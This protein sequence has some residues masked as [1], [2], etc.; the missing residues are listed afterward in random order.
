[1]DKN[2]ISALNIQ[3]YFIIKVL[4][5]TRLSEVELIFDDICLEGMSRRKPSK[6]E[7][8]NLKYLSFYR[9]TLGF[10]LKKKDKRRKVIVVNAIAT[11][12]VF[13]VALSCMLIFSGKNKPS[14]A[15]NIEK[16]YS[17]RCERLGM[18]FIYATEG[19]DIKISVEQL[20]Y[21]KDHM[22]KD[23]SYKLD[24]E[25]AKR[26]ERHNLYAD[27]INDEQT[28]CEAATFNY[29]G[30]ENEEKLEYVQGDRKYVFNEVYNI[31]FVI[32]KYFCT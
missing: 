20:Y 1:M 7:K 15:N 17:S 8:E 19:K 11:G 32:I 13:L 9:N 24:T 22:I 4:G 23:Y 6:E 16:G 31:L 3:E 25:L 21:V 27:S 30:L 18:N 10:E 26:I 5:E 12:V 28:V 14:K 2:H 29:L